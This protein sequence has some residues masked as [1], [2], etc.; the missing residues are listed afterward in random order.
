MQEI[1]KKVIPIGVGVLIGVIFAVASAV[2]WFSKQ[3]GDRWTYTRQLEWMLDFKHE[4]PDIIVKVP[5]P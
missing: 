3:T 1:S 5:H 4:N 2:W